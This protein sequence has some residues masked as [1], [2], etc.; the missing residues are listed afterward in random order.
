[1]MHRNRSFSA[2]VAAL[3]AAVLCAPVAAQSQLRPPAE[4]PPA[5]YAGA[6]YVDSRGCV[7]IRAGNAGQ[8]NWV[9]RVTRDR[10]PVCGFQPTLAAATA[11]QRSAAPAPEVVEIGASTPARPTVTP[12]VRAGVGTVF[13][14]ETASAKGVGPRTRVLPRH[15]YE[16]RSALPPVAVPKGYRSAWDDDRLNPQRAEQS[17]QG[18]GA[19]R[20]VWTSTVPRRLREER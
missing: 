4:V 8:T 2:V 10:K 15:L 6:Q 7:Y 3:V 9:P 19:M 5:S 20:Q 12:P 14:P 13:T 18:L 17:L 16:Q 11:P 1:M